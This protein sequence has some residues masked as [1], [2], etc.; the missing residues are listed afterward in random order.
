MSCGLLEHETNEASWNAPPGPTVICS[1][2]K[3]PSTSM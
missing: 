1:V 2:W 3:K